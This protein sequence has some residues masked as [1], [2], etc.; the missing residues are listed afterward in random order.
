MP[1]DASIAA[2]S[3]SLLWDTRTEL[4]PR[5]GDLKR[6]SMAAKFTGKDPARTLREK[7]TSEYTP[8]CLEMAN[9]RYS[10]GDGAEAFSRVADF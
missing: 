2:K 3:R 7:P 5:S 9:G 6:A 10:W 8:I 4:C 1:H